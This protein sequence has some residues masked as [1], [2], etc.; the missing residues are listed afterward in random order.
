MIAY[1]H[2]IKKYFNLEKL[3][4]FELVKIIRS[5]EMIEKIIYFFI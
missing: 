4:I 5:E 2:N 3:Y 1:D